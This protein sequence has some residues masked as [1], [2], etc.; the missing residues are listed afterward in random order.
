M[1]VVILMENLPG[2][3]LGFASSNTKVSNAPPGEKKQLL[4]LGCW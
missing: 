1:V 2:V 3:Q 4:S